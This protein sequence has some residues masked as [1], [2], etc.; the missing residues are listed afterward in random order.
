[1]LTRLIFEFLFFF[2]V[3]WRMFCFNSVLFL[4]ALISLNA[5]F[6]NEL[7]DVGDTNPVKKLS[8]YLAPST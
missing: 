3:T 1:M 8:L 6:D 7:M 4:Y 5:F 2:F